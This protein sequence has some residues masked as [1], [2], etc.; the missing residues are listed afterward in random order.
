MRPVKLTVYFLTIA[1][2][3]IMVV[4]LSS[5]GA[6]QTPRTAAVLFEG[7]RLITGDGTA[8]IENSAF[9]V[10]NSR[11][12]RVGRRGEVQ[13]PAGA[14]RVDLSGKTVIPGMIDLHTHP[15]YGSNAPDS[16]TRETLV[17]HLQRYA[18]YG[19][20]VIVSLGQDQGDLAFQIRANPIPGAALYRTA[21]LGVA[22]PGGGPPG[23]RATI[24]YGVTNEAQARKAVQELSTKKVDF[25]KIW[26]DDRMGT[27][28]KMPPQLYRPIIE[29]AH[30]QNLRVMAHI[31]DLADAKELLRSGIDG[32]AHGVRDRD[33]DEEF[34]QLMKERP[35]VF[36]IP[37]LPDRGVAEELTW[38]SGTVRPDEITRL[39]AAQANRKP[40]AVQQTRE[41]YG[42]QARNLMK[43]SAAG[44]KIGF[45]EDGTGS[46]WTA[47]TEL[48]DMVAAGLT[49]SQVITAATRTS[50]EIMRLN[51]LGT[52][53]TGKSAD[54]VVLD[55]NPLDDIT[56]TRRIAR[57]YLRGQEED[58][59]GLRAA[60]TG[61]GSQ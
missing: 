10:E 20:A 56:N 4:T 33:I 3:I 2:G 58:R 57:V 32:F 39:T 40:D 16:Y 24:P 48:A 30:K 7:A 1:L 46:G 49:P 50:A 26:V 42:I 12:T 47:Q 29:E 18:Y 11:F 9:I 17:E 61:R 22:V 6:G 19:F 5:Q 25:V 14:V 21:G 44:V 55:A 43:L 28:P 51:Q 45:G 13:A 8:P 31:Y 27:Q 35:N 59:A 41:L 38:L 52:I 54:F 37:N 23:V 60:W 15:G 53:A 34:M 36:V